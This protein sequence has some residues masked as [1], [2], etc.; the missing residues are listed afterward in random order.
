[1]YHPDLAFGMV[2]HWCACGSG[3]G[4]PNAG[5]APL[6]WQTRNPKGWSI[7]PK[8]FDRWV[9]FG[10]APPEVAKPL[11]GRIQRMRASISYVIEMEVSDAEPRLG[12][13]LYDRFDRSLNNFMI[14]VSGSWSCHVT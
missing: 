3:G 9:T 8:D 11:D 10:A 13:A 6:Q 12:L 2:C 1:M 4:A 7:Q 5:C 14:H